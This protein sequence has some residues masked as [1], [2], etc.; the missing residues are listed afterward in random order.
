MALTQVTGPYPIFTDLDGSPLDDGYLYI[1]EVN[2]DPETN[3]I[4]VFWDSN[5]TIPATQPIRTSNGYAYRNGTPALLYTGGEFSIT[6]RN[7]KQE[8]VLYSPV[9]YGFDPGSVSASVTKNDFTGDG[10]T[11]DFTISATPTTI[12]ATNIFINGVYQEKDSYSILGNVVT[13]SIAP[14]ISS[15]IEILTNQTGIINTGYANDITYTAGF[16]GAVAQ[17]VQTKLEQTISVK[18]FGAIGDGVTDDTAAIQAAIDSGEKAIFFPAGTYLVG[19]LSGSLNQQVFNGEGGYASILKRKSG[20]TNILVHSG[21]F[22]TFSGLT[23]RGIVTDSNTNLVLNGY[24]WELLNCNSDTTTGLVLD[25]TYPGAFLIQGGSYNNDNTSGICVRIGDPAASSASLY[26]RITDMVM[27]SSGVSLSMYGCQTCSIWGG[28]MGGIEFLDGSGGA[29]AGAITISGVRITGDVTVD[30]SGNI[31]CGNKFGAGTTVTLGSSGNF[32]FGNSDS[33][34]TVVNPGNA[35]NYMV[36]QVSGGGQVTMRVGANAAYA[37]YGLDYINGITALPGN[38]N[39]LND[40]RIRFYD[41]TGTLQNGVFL[42]SG[43]DWSFG[44][45]NGANS[46]SVKSGTGGVYH[47]VGGSSITLTDANKF[48][49]VP[50]GTK[51]LGGSSN[52]WATVY[53]TT[54]TINTS[55]ARDKHDIRPLSE[56]EKA[57]GVALRGLI[58]AYKWNSGAAETYVGVIAQDVIAAFEAQGLNARDYGIIDDSGDRLGVRY[59]QVFAFVIGSL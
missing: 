23:F 37:D 7:K 52:R 55:D 38:V 5:L 42:T 30:G 3:P 4:Q 35:N 20:A 12:L 34:T 56:K 47:E 58:R 40:K 15:S 10:V 39:F 11:V 29:S 41:S 2:Q 51:N 25:A 36:R 24:D 46:A 28:Q 22:V 59:D 16:A 14:P 53:A 32:Y 19:D 43:D 21:N 57:V 50:D 13:F 8:F 17:T 45:N 49:P 6:I 26:G 54:G 9:G 33:T 31:I 18:D 44:A 1:G 27:H 48:A